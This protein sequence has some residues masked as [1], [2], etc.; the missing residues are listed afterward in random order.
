MVQCMLGEYIQKADNIFYISTPK[1]MYFFI[2]TH[3]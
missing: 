3:T 1:T 2:Y